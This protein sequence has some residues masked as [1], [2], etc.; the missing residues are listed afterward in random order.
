MNVFET[1]TTSD[2]SVT[3]FSP[4]FGET[5]HTKFG[6][7]KEAEISFVQGCNLLKKAQ[8]KSVIKIIDICYGLGYNT[9]A[10]L[11]SIWSINPHCKIE[12][13][14]LE[15]DQK[16]PF[17]AIE[18]QLL[19]LWSEPIPSLLT[20]LAQNQLVSTNNLNAQLFYEDAR[21][22][23]QKIAKIGFK[24]D[25]IFLDPFSPPKCPQLWTVDFITLVTQCLDHQGRIA[26]YSCSAALRSAL[27]LAGLKI[28]ANFCIGRR[29]PGTI[30]SFTEENLPPLSEKEKEHLNTRAAIPYRDPSLSDSAEIIKQRRQEEQ[31]LSNLEPS[32]QWKKR[33]FS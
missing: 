12:L 6:A 13:F 21:I 7:K 20:N 5:F 29:S 18:N 17:Q 14:A 16:V 2:G 26:T 4:E 3:F 23:I 11:D 25:A 22:S 30:A 27:I 19:T 32:S 1:R 8:E 10:A 33:W 28:G 24:A 15:Y 9:A 31:T